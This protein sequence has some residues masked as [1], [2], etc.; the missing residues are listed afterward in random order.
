MKAISIAQFCTANAGSSYDQD[1]GEMIIDFLD[2]SKNVN[3]ESIRDKD[4]NLNFSI[5]IPIV[6][7]ECIAY[8]ATCE[9]LISY[10]MAGS[11]LH[12]VKNVYTVCDICYNALLWQEA[13]PHPYGLLTQ[14]NAFQDDCLVK[15]SEQTFNAIWKAELTF[16]LVRKD[17]MKTENIN[18][19]DAL[20]NSLQY[21]WTSSTIPKCHNITTKILRR[22]FTIRYKQF[23]Q[24][25]R[26]E[27]KEH[28][29]AFS[30]KSVTMHKIIK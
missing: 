10:D 1:D 2:V 6:T 18:V 25:K 29:N 22:Y 4:P 11:T 30:S 3:V 19:Y 24:M 21:V 14:L 16:R 12:S 8:F 5:N 23:G 20:V 15:V 9:R 17:L 13:E 28:G 7:N 27:L 26:Q